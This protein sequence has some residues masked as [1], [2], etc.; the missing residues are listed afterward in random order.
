MREGEYNPADY[1]P[2]TNKDV[3]QMY[4]ELMKYA[5]KVSNP[6]MKKLVA[7]SNFLGKFSIF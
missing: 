2:T 7:L 4:T 1:V 6:Y 3:E 5:E